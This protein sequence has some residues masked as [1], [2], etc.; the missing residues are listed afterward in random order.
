MIGQIK[1]CRV[2]MIGIR[3]SVK[4]D[5]A[6]CRIFILY[7]LCISYILFH[8]FSLCVILLP[9]EINNVIRNTS[10]SIYADYK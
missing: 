7:Y 10:D 3:F 4:Q 9:T 1:E 8:S 5:V 6:C 2:T